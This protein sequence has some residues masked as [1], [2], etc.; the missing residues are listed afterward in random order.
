MAQDRKRRAVIVGGVRTPFV[1]A[2]TD[3]VELDTI[4]LG[5]AAVR[6]LLARTNLPYKAAQGIVCGGGASPSQ[7]VAERRPRDRA[8]SSARPGVRGDDGHP[9]M[10]LGAPGD[11]A[12]RRQHR[13]RRGRRDDRRRERLDEQRRG[14]APVEA[15]ARDGTARPRKADAGGLLRG[16]LQARPLHRSPPRAP[17]DRGA[18]DRR[19]DG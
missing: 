12:G 17:A 13:A 5:V 8:R 19:G 15:H 3:F 16:P 6:G 2:F 18:D 9:G 1:K 10:R 14:E 11:H 4:A 7:R